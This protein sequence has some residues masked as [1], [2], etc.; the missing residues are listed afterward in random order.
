MKKT[1]IALA[2][3]ALTGCAGVEQPKFVGAATTQQEVEDRMDCKEQVDRV[4]MDG[5]FPHSLRI[6]RCLIRRG[7]SAP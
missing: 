1:L 2:A 7:Y 6:E 4:G 3:L 5:A